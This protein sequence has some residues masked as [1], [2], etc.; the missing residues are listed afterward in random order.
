MKTYVVI[1]LGRFGVAAALKLQELGNE[2][3]AI[4]TNAELVESISDS[5]TYAVVG[6]AQDE[7]VLHSL[8]VKNYDCAVVAIGNDL[9]ASVL[10]TLNLKDLGMKKIICKAHDDLEKRAL[11]K[12]GADRVIIPERVMGQK[13]AQTLNAE[14]FLDFIELSEEYSVAELTAP[15]RWV[16][17]SLQEL[18][19]RNKYHINVI[20]AKR[21]G[22]VLV[23]LPAEFC[24]EQEDVVILLGANA[25]LA[26]IRKL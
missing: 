4:D 25:D 9:A 2:V 7:R 26:R 8:G 18:N 24:F 23:S 20:A 10:I 16:G 12:I 21:G 19:L 5:V 14:R 22:H 11:E 15:A 6:D 17:H 13:L 1:G 3:L